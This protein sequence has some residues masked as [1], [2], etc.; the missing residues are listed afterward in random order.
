MSTERD[1]RVARC[2]RDYPSPRA[3]LSPQRREVGRGGFSPPRLRQWSRRANFTDAGHATLHRCSRH[4]DFRRPSPRRA[5]SRG[6]CV[7][8]SRQDAPPRLT[9][10][11]RSSTTGSLSCTTAPLSCSGAPVSSTSKSCDRYDCCKP[12]APPLRAADTNATLTRTSATA[13]RNTATRAFLSA[14]GLTH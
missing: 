3:F 10:G 5:F 1:R 12:S 6:H 14:A 2:E 13:T 8:A 7:S 4:P 11:S 9:T